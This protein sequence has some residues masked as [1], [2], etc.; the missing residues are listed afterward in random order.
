MLRPCAQYKTLRRNRKPQYTSTRRAWH[1]NPPSQLGLPVDMHDKPPHT[2]HRRNSSTL[3]VRTTHQQN[4]SSQ[5][6]PHRTPR[7]LCGRMRQLIQSSACHGQVTV[8]TFSGGRE[9]RE[10][11]SSVLRTSKSQSTRSRGRVR[12]W[13]YSL[14]RSFEDSKAT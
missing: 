9:T 14:Q 3:V 12:L 10:S 6:T 2:S 7:S 1:S 8:L 4:H 11:R 13:Q 5:C